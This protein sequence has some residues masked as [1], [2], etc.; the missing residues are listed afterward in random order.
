MDSI[1]DCWTASRSLTRND[2][3]EVIRELGGVTPLPDFV[4]G[5]DNTKILLTDLATMG[6]KLAI[7]EQVA[8]AGAGW[9]LVVD[10]TRRQMSFATNEEMLMIL[11]MAQAGTFG[12]VGV[13]GL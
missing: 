1:V 2:K 12:D 9:G 7:R 5:N 13:V 11:D 8:S 6:V 3:L 10:W 4:E